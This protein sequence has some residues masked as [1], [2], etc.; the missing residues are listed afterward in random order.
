M[1]GSLVAPL[2]VRTML[3]Y[4]A[5][6]A[7]LPQ[8]IANHANTASDDKRVTRPVLGTVCQ[9]LPMRHLPSPPATCKMSATFVHT[10]RR[11]NLLR[12]RVTRTGAL[13]L[14]HALTHHDEYV[15]TVSLVTSSGFAGG[16]SAE[17]APPRCTP[18]APSIGATGAMSEE[19]PIT[20]DEALQWLEQ[21]RKYVQES[22]CQNAGP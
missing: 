16:H 17:M 14:A 5:I 11:P 1:D 12:V 13:S 9:P 8:A 21:Q 7:Q 2:P 15:A 18:R 3:T 22:N 10:S 6:S 20:L 19:A 4:L